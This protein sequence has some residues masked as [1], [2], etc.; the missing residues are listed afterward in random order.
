M[1]CGYSAK[2]EDYYECPRREMLEFIPESALRILDV[3]CGSG[4]FGRSLKQ[5][6]GAVVWG[7]E[8]H[9]NAAEQA[10][11]ALDHVVHAPFDEQTDL[12]RHGFDCVIFNDV[13]EHLVNPEVA[14]KVAATLLGSNG[15]IVASIP[16]LR[17]FPTLWR[18]V[19]EGRWEYT[20]RGILD[21]THLRFFT[22]S[23]VKLLFANAGFEVQ[24]FRGINEFASF[25]PA[26]DTLWRRYG[27]LRRW[28]VP[29]TEDM[30][31]LQFAV[32]A[33]PSGI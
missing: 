32:V 14:L 5:I 19:I 30:K 24:K 26:D 13:L 7:V 12:P 20:E 21:H 1:E 16:N 3:G 17:H 31:Y 15:V 8:A 18:L 27:M 6:R 29:R 10:A 25:G 28:R 11:T 4:T 9:K 33:S 23:S 2:R 22:A